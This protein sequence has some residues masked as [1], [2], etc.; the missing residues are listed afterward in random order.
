MISAAELMTA[1]PVTLPLDAKVRLAVATLQTMDIRHLPVID[2]DG[3]LVGIVSDRDLRALEIPSVIGEEYLGS[4]RA[5]LDAPLASI[6]SGDVIYVDTETSASEI[7]DL[8]L[9]NKIG[10]VPVVDVDGVLVGIVSYVDVLRALPFEEAP[11]AS[12]ARRRDRAS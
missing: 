11:V 9:E 10:A 12:P 4:V 8:M 2:E 5:A 6:M 7:V 3:A 1:N